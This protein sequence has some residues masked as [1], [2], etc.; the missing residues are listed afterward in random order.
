MCV[1]IAPELGTVQVEDQGIQ[2]YDISIL[3]LRKRRRP[4]VFLPLPESYE[5]LVT[6]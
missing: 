5:G 6:N 3:I 1:R 2:E 4:F